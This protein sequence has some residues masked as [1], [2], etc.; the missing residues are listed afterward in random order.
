MKHVK[1][2]KSFLILLLSMFLFQGLAY[3][4]DK[5]TITTDKILSIVMAGSD[6]IYGI[7][8]ETDK[9]QEK[10][11][12]KLYIELLDYSIG[13]ATGVI[14]L[15]KTT[16]IGD[17]IIPHLIEKKNTP[18]TCL[19]EF[20]SRCRT[21]LERNRFINYII[22]ARKKGIII[23]SLFPD[24]LLMSM[25]KDLNIIRTF[26]EDYKIS[27]GK[28]PKD[29]Y[30]LKEYVWRKYGYKLVIFSHYFG[31]PFIYKVQEDKYILDAGNDEAP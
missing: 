1:T 24:D 28:Y 15:E 16:S 20:K 19:G 7:L 4:E 18:I 3:A 27:S 17:K 22:D 23:Y 13:E 12:I 26:L 9:L 8:E 5:T 29:L 30:Q 14:L 10:E 31:K 2:K 21:D 11:A 25:E 6:E